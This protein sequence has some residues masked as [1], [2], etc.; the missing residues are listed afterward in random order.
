MGP[1]SRRNAS[2]EHAV[3]QFDLYHRSFELA[4]LQLS[5]RA[6]DVPIFDFFPGLRDIYSVVILVFRILRYLFELG[7]TQGSLRGAR[8]HP[9]SDEPVLES[10]S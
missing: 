1:L 9:K 6:L 10:S 3:T 4:L 8:R 5:A 2:S 7:R